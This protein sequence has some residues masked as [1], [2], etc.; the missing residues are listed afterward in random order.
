MDGKKPA[1]F[2]TA[3]EKIVKKAGFGKTY[4]SIHYDTLWLHK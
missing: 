4:V 2:K 3:F 1:D